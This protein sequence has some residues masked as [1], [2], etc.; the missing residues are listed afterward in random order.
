MKVAFDLLEIV[1]RACEDLGIPYAIGGSMASMTYGELRTTR[2]VDVVVSLRGVDVPRL[3]ARF[4]LSEFY[5][6]Q[7]AAL[8]A[9][10]TGGEF[11]IIDNERGL[12]IDVFVADDEISERQI[13][14]ARRLPLPSGGT[15]MF[16]APEELILKKLQYY[17]FGWSEKHLRDVA[18]MLGRPG[19]E[20]DR[21]RI[22][23]LAAEYGLSNVWEAVLARLARG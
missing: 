22:T 3:L 5:H 11:N 17:G 23:A 21:A 1:A 15:A 16:S 19:A 18:G 10:R 8:E 4:P 7:R 9:V 14:H 20:I 6:D 13:A 12:K 2:D